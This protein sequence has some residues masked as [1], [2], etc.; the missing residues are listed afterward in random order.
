MDIDDIDLNSLVIDSA[1]DDNHI[2]IVTERS[3]E[4]QIAI[5]GMSTQIGSAENSDA[6]W[7]QLISQK[8]GIRHFPKVRQK[9]VESLV[10]AKGIAFNDLSE[11]FLSSSYLS[12]ID[13]FDYAFFG[14]SRSEADVMDPNQRILL[15][16]AWSALENAG[17]ACEEI[18]GSNTGVF[19]GF[20]QDF[21]DGYDQFINTHVPH[22]SEIAVVGNIKSI[23]ASR[24]AYQ[25]DLVG[26]SMMI[27]TA[28]S[29]SL[30]AVYQAS[31]AI[32]S[33][34]CDMA[35]AG[36]IKIDFVPLLH[37]KHL[38]DVGV[39]DIKENL[40]AD[41]KNKTFDNDCDGMT[42]GEGTGIFVLKSY[43][44]AKA[45]GD[46]IYAT[47]LGGAINQDGS[48]VGITAPNSAAQEKLILKAMQDAGITAE[49]YRYIEAHGTATKLGDP[50][51]LKGLEKAFQ[52]YTNKNQFCAI[53]SV[54]SNVG[55]LDN[56]AG[57]SGLSKVIL[58]MQHN[59]IPASLHFNVPN[60]A[61]SFIDSPFYVAANAEPLDAAANE[62]WIAGINSFGLSG[63]N[64]HLILRSEKN[65][66]QHYI[67]NKSESNNPDESFEKS[68]HQV[69]HCLVMSAKNNRSLAQLV[70]LY[71]EYVLQHG[72]T[73]DTT[74]IN[75]WLGDVCYTAAV[76]RF[77]FEKR[78][79]FTFKQV[80][81]LLDLLT[82]V[83]RCFILQNKDQFEQLLKSV[84]GV[85]YSAAIYPS[86]EQKLP[87][88]I[89]NENSILVSYL[90]QQDVDW[91]QYYSS[92]KNALDA[93]SLNRIPLP[94]YPF[95]KTRCWVK[96]QGDNVIRHGY[97][98]ILS[99]PLLQGQ[100]LNSHHIRVFESV[101]SVDT[102]WELADHKVKGSHILPGTCYV[103]MMLQAFQAC[104]LE[105]FKSLHFNKVQFFSPLVVDSKEQRRV[106]VQLK[107]NHQIIE[108]EISSQLINQNA[109]TAQLN[110][111]LENDEW[112]THAAATIDLN[113]DE[114]QATLASQ[115]NIQ[116]I[117]TGEA[118]HFDAN[119]DKS[120]GLE[121]GDRWNKCAEM[122]W[123]DDTQNAA[124]RSVLVKLHLPEE[125]K[126]DEG[127]YFYHPSLFDTAVNSAIHLIKSEGLYLPL[128]YTDF[129]VYAQ[130]PSV[131]Y[132]YIQPIE[133]K[134]NDLA[135]FSIHFLDSEANVVASVAE[136]NVK[137]VPEAEKFTQ[138][139][140]RIDAFTIGSKPF[141]PDA[142]DFDLNAFNE[143]VSP[144]QLSNKQVLLVSNQ[145]QLNDEILTQLHVAGVSSQLLNLNDKS[146]EKIEAELT[147]ILSQQVNKG[148]DDIIIL[149]EL[150]LNETS[151]EQSNQSLYQLVSLIN[152]I[153]KSRIALSGRILFVTQST[154]QNDHK[155]MVNP[156]NLAARELIQILQLENPQLKIQIIDFYKQ[157]E[158]QRILS[159]LASGVDYPMIS[160]TSK[161]VNR[162]RLRYTR[163][164]Q[165]AKNDESYYQP[166]DVYLITG[167]VGA[168]A[169][170][171]A[172]HI[173]KQA[174]VKFALL[175]HRQLPA[176]S[177]WNLAIDS[178]ATDGKLK[179][180]L[181]KLLEI[182]QLGSEVRIFSGNIA[183]ANFVAQSINTI[184]QEFHQIDGIVHAAGRAGDGFALTK[185]S[186]VFSQVVDPKIKGGWHLH[187]L[188]LQEP[189]KFFICYSSVATILRAAG[190]S[191]YTA[192]NAFLDGLAQ[193]RREQ[194]LPGV[195]VG[196]PAWREVGI[197]VEYNAVDE[198][199]IFKPINTKDALA[200]IDQVLFHTNELPSAIVLSEL[201]TQ[202]DPDVFT[203][204]GLTISDQLGK[205]FK[206]Q[207]LKNKAAGEGEQSST[208]TKVTLVDG[209]DADKYLTQVAGIWAKV[210]GV[211]ELSRDSQFNE[212]GGNSVLTIEL[213]REYES[214][215]PNTIDMAD[216]FTHT[217]VDS[218]AGF[219]RNKFEDNQKES[220][221]PD[222]QEDKN[223]DDILE[224]IARGEIS[225]EAAQQYF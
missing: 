8:T 107:L 98:Q 77:H 115:I 74:L 182:R 207:A 54:K 157:L 158:S 17:Y 153:V 95:D 212:L 41:G 216:L 123:Y 13:E 176:E 42:I 118:F 197:A 56:A 31:Q 82:Q 100:L 211:G 37:S 22:A 97:Q 200:A 40:A 141:N 15:Q 203:R 221:Q 87:A 69:S 187:Q 86:L 75:Q 109:S 146:V 35:L 214:L 168:L 28:C 183:D 117:M 66:S 34:Q 130:L 213:F 108:V 124:T 135:K 112:I 217:T 27:D 218:Q 209:D 104:Q 181:E 39:R 14:L 219:F 23:I 186:E 83:S 163:L 194:G 71:Y 20:S 144:G 94:V 67:S 201:N 159:A 151:V 167:G 44:K 210:L 193:Y 215:Y 223:I 106:H 205:R 114:H 45:D 33:G 220:Q 110:Q 171:L 64:C 57:I 139:K 7:Q 166:G 47:I 184:K 24:I 148:L 90:E 179:R 38:G 150:A 195:S 199:E 11:Q 178:D 1:Q 145:P 125:F 102:H 225:V 143:R 222:I 19:I 165:F 126:S 185:T 121:I 192:A 128:S 36:G 204:Q 50:V 132:V 133:S 162:E 152:N 147:E 172:V 62:S 161:K 177:D 96:H 206:H 140:T 202:A 51:E 68:A 91:R 129:V 32:R 224:K 16:T 46:F 48:S 88:K 72:Q 93:K 52:H 80:D 9:D 138:P 21:G 58:A 103:E 18:K 10:S 29:S 137:Y 55:H 60:Q 149:S 188:T 2:E 136:Y 155:G 169:L 59:T 26:P 208:V 61:I 105:S 3:H 131:F 101:L 113:Y 78:L 190:Q 174:K 156:I 198:N 76:G 73:I 5:I 89:T 4:N 173:A 164:D 116:R 12:Q 196:W 65:L 111:L 189:L 122:G 84:E 99:S 170:E 160:L 191:D 120:R 30:V 134:T 180:Q 79:V 6:F 175:V 53:G 85:Y 25:L 43:A 142:V 127:L 119:E 49:D 154:L 81:Q 70:Q 92:N 63:T